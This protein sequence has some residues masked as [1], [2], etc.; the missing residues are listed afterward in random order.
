VLFR[1]HCPHRR[2]MLTSIGATHTLMRRH[3]QWWVTAVGDVPGATLR[4]FDSAL[5]FNRK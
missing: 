2:E 3:G 1:S 4:L 5:E